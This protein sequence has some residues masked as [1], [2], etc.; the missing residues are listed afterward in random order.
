[1]YGTGVWESADELRETW[2]L[3]RRFEPV[4]DRKTADAAHQKWRSAVERAKGWAT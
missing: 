2:A 4:A 3:D 1:M